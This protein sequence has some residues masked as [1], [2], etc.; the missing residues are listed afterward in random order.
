LILAYILHQLKAQNE[1]ALHSPFV[2][3]LYTKVIKASHQKYYAFR[4]IEALRKKML[5]D[6]SLIEVQDFGAG[7]KI[8]KG[9]MRKVKSIARH[10][11]APPPQ[12]RL[13][14]RLINHYQ[15]QTIIELGTSLGIS[16]L[17]MAKACSQAQIYTF[18][19]CPN[20]AQIAQENF[21]ILETT[22]IHSLVGNIEETL[23]QT[24]QKIQKLDVAVLD[25]NHRFTPTLHYF[26]LC[27][28][29]AHANSVFILDD[30]Y[31]SKEMTQAWQQIQQHPQ[32]TLTIDL[33]EVGLVFFHK[34]HPKQ[35]FKLR[36]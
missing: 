29:K 18:E 17:Y 34:K 5:Y 27:L 16:T 1:Y 12:A 28:S 21:E 31:W 26:E 8:Q 11:L 4:Q 6:D 10:S 3:D 15:P 23:P 32:V 20:I 33:F 13:L 2:Y 14:F 9:N 22:H 25:A 7:S 36:F 35:H 19:G 30:I 24:L